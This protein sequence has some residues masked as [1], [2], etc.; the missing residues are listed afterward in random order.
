MTRMHEPQ[1]GETLS[2]AVCELPDGL[3]PG[4]AAWRDLLDGVART[5][6]QALLLNELPFGRWPAASPAFE[7]GRAGRTAAAH[8]AGIAAL[9]VLASLTPLAPLAL[10]GSTALPAGSKL[11]NEGFVRLERRYHALHHKLC[12]PEEPGFH[13]D[14]WFCPGSRAFGTFDHGG[15]RFAFAICS[16]LMVPEVPRMLARLGA[17]VLLV[18]RA[19]TAEGFDRWLTVARATAL[20]TGCYVASSNRAGGG[21][22]AFGGGGFVIDPG[23]E[24]LALT[25]PARPLAAVTLSR[26]T[27][28]RARAAYPMTIR[29]HL[30]LTP[31]RPA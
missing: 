3:S 2:L 19:S 16:E 6:P 12:L 29:T 1:D 23:G 14:T 21:E 25:D 28:T 20:V 5:R 17:D 26:A 27:L 7:L 22:P 24:L 8:A 18:P 30:V 11:I 4:D 15:F 10:F 31:P 13:E 9:D